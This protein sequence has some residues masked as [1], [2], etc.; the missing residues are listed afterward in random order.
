M[1]KI[2]RL[3]I[4]LGKNTLRVCPIARTGAGRSTARLPGSAR[5][6]A[7]SSGPTEAPPALWSLVE[8]TCRTAM[9]QNLC[10]VTPAPWGDRTSPAYGPSR[11]HFISSLAPAFG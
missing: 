9:F 1:S 4:G 11:V 5:R 2:T 10:S 6:N 8:R 7:D 3:G